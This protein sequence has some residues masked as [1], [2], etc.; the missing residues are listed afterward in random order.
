MT[1]VFLYFIWQHRLFNFLDLKLVTGENAEII[2]PGQ[3]NFHAGP[4]FK[5]AIIKIND[6]TWIGDVEIH[7]QSSDWL[8]HQHHKDEKYKS[9]ILHVVY[10]ADI[11]INRDEH[12]N[13]PVLEL[14]QLIAPSL[15]EK[16]QY[17]QYSPMRFPCRNELP[18][19]SA[20]TF[21]AW[22]SRL[23]VS[24]LT[25]KEKRIFEILHQVEEDWNEL[26]FRLLGLNFGFNVNEPAFELLVRTLSYKMIKRH[27]PTRLQCYALICGTAGFL[28]ES[29]DKFDDYYHLLHTEFAFLRRKLNILPIPTSIW[30]FLRLHPQNFP[31]LRLEQ[32]AALLLQI[33]H[34]FVTFIIN[35]KNFRTEVLSNY[36]PD[37]YW[38]THYHFGK[39]SKSHTISIGKK[40]AEL[41]I[42]NTLIPVLYAFGSFTGKNSFKEEAM[43][44]LEKTPFESNRITRLY[45]SI[46]FPSQS[47]L[48]SQALLELFRYY[49]QRKKCLYCQIGC[50]I[51]RK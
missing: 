49:C 30:N 27:A 7:S 43:H 37:S 23:A 11:I 14:K 1:E 51:L 40:S 24:R 38:E 47:A 8:K 9:V 46:G 20:L 4:D 19:I 32:F 44:L 2:S 3:R 36:K 21:H 15:I 50:H 16:Y 42:I 41:I 33:P 6:I 35:G 28:E 17:L 13:F 22:L 5:Q 34:L 39:E 10:E 31:A 48:D 25:R 26:I 29:A 12:E 45:T 18:T